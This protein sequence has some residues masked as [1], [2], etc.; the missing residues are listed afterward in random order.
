[1]NFLKIEN[2]SEFIKKL[3]FYFFIYMIL[4]GILRK[5]IF[6]NFNV[7]IYF[8]KDFFLLIIY[9]LAI[10]YNFLFKSKFSIY[11]TIFVTLIS[12]YGLIGYSFNSLESIIYYSLGVRSYWLY[13]P[14]FLVVIHIITLEDVIKFLRFNFFCIIPYFVLIYFQSIMPDTSII[15]SGRNQL[16]FNPERPSGYFTF[17]TQNTFYFIFLSI[18]VNFYVLNLNRVSLKKIC[19]IFIINFLLLSILILLKSRAVYIFLF[20]SLIYSFIFLLFSNEIKNL[21]IIKLS[22]FVI[23]IPVTFFICSKIYTTQF[24]FSVKRINTDTY[25]ELSLVKNLGEN[26]IFKTDLTIREF[27]KKQSSICRIV[28]E[29]YFFSQIPK[30]SISGKG[31]GSGTSA[32][33]A[34]KK[35]ANFALGEAENHRIIH[36]LGTLVGPFYVI[37][38]YVF[39]LLMSILFIFKHKYK[40]QLSPLL[41]FVSVQMVIGS[42]TFSVS[43]I[44]F[45]FWV[46]FAIMLASFTFKEKHGVASQ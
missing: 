7:Q 3:L 8:I 25:H 2:P 11:A 37:F 26:K 5:W 16:V 21:K 6:P 42:V 35:E 10:K 23:V 18:C 32:V 30:A 38:K 44:S 9:A 40:K 43:F 17:T 46:C 31:I 27:C 4:E 36:E 20:G 12:L 22:F 13:F 45:I 28:N 15:N 33:S 24:D 34:V 14:L 29:I 41:L 19:Y 1:M 39:V